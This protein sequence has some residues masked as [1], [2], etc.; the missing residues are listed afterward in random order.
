M[1]KKRRWTPFAAVRDLFALIYAI[2]ILFPL[3]WIIYTSLKT[4]QEFVTDPWGLPAVPQWENYVSAWIKVDF[5]T[6][7]LNSIVITLVSVAIVVVLASTV[8]YILART[9][10]R[11]SRAAR[12]LIIAGLYVPVTLLLP[13]LF[14][15]MYSL[16]L[17]NSRP[18]LVAVYVVFSL[19]YSV[20]VLNSFYQS[21]PVELEEAAAIDGCGPHQTFWRVVFPLSKNGIIT[22]IIFNFVWIW[23]DY[24][25]ALTLIQENEN[26]TLPVGIVSLMSTFKLKAD[27]VTLFAGLNIVMI[28]SVLLYI[29]FQKYLTKGLTTGSV[30]G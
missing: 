8:S 16:G 24:I 29:V 18:G 1:N 9:K 4:N 26:M 22:V 13:S 3:S 11:W 19:P 25:F 7:A 23:N 20:L 14:T 17:W 30:K 28:P 27:W 12:M 5:R 10:T 15:T 21:M 6:Y 2:G